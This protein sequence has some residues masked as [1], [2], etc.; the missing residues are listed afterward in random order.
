MLKVQDL[1]YSYP[2]K[3]L[4]N[5]V[6]FTIEDNIHCVLIGT[7]GTGKSTLIDL[8]M[9]PEEHL[10]DG[11]IVIENAD[12]IGYVS[13]FSQLDAREDMTVFQYISAEFL[14][15]EQKLLDFYKEM[16]TAVDIETTLENY[17]KEVDEWNAIDGE[18]YEINIKKQLKF[19]NLQKLQDQN[20][21][22]LSGG[23]FKLIQVIREMLLSPTFLI[24]D[25]P[26]VFLDFEHLNALRNLINAHKGTLLVITHNRYLLNHCFNKILHMEN[27]D[28][29]EFNG[30]YT[31][32]NYELLATKIDLQE[33]VAAE[34]KEIDCQNEILHKARDKAAEMD[35]SSL[36]RIVHARQSLVNRLIARKTKAPF[37]DIKQPEICFDLENQVEDENILELTEYSV[38]FDEQLLDHVNFEMKQA[39]HVAIIG[40]NGTGKTTMLY[41]ILENKK[42]TIKMSKDAKVSMFAQNTGSLYNEAKTLV[43]IFEEK[44]FDSKSDIEDYLKKYGFERETLGQKMS[45]LSGGEKDLFQLAMLSLEKSNFLLLDEPTGHLDVYAQIA[46][47]Q[48]ITEYK[49]AILMVS[50]DYYTVANCMDYVLLLENN[51]VRRMSIRKFRQMIYANHFDKDYLLLEQKKIETETTIQRLLRV[52]EFE[53]AKALMSSLEEIIQKMKK[54]AT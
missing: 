49:G 31:E 13:Q 6:S 37:V 41:D 44:G 14:K 9:H 43:E 18:F 28:I 3:D 33:A 12:K 30:T 40:G 48:V 29:Q 21:S 16:E 27:M 26:D 45:E 19:A 42:N 7:N 47:E 39:D 46:L 4:Y 23:E 17:Q 25:E 20:I 2:Q 11:K 35:N 1:S 54:S 34:Q 5:K 8:L 52:N 15:H 24:M 10:Y 51:T 32:Y 38:E 53:K 50:H 36:G 22:S